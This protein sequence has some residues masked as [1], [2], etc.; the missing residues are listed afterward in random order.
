MDAAE[1]QSATAA[2]RKDSGKLSEHSSHS[3]EKKAAAKVVPK[4]V[5]ETG[6]DLSKD[7]KQT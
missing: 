2:V 1:T 3:Q 7:C 6:A 4:E 5:E